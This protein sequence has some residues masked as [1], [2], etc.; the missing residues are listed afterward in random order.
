MRSR[1]EAMKNPLAASHGHPT[2]LFF[3]TYVSR[4]SGASHA[5]RETMRNVAACGIRPLVVL[6]DSADSREM[7]LNSE[8]EALYLKIHRPRRT[9]KAWVHARWAVNSMAMFFSLRRLLRERNVDVVHCNEV[10]D[11]VAGLAAKSGGVPCICHVR[12][13]RPPNPYR[14]L[15]LSTIEKV[16]DAVIV[17]S[18]CTAEW[19]TRGNKKLAQ[20]TRLIYDYAF[21]I[22]AYNSPQCGA[23]FRQELGIQPD[24]IMVLLV[25]KLVT[26]KGHE[27]FIRAAEKVREVLKDVRFVVVGGPVP[28]HEEEAEAIYS[29]A[30]RLTPAPQLQFA[31]ARADLPPIY[32]ASDIVVH[33]PTYRDP[34]PTVVLLAMAARRPIIGS[35]VGGIPEQI[36]HN[37]TGMLIPA[38]DPHAL[39]RAIIELSRN[40]AKRK[41]LETAG[42]DWVRHNFSPQTQ[43]RL[44]AAVYSQMLSI[45][46]SKN[47]HDVCHAPAVEGFL[48]AHD[49]LDA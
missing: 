35:M 15:L 25:S 41:L 42:S 38:N 29:L 12:T 24:E 8:F 19:L 39:A 40:P 3:S 17:T 37:H 48:E 22:R 23:A 4:E 45:P 2:V 20:R 31:G 13:D 27:C 18:K 28:G 36:E 46:D 5:L 21:D 10:T 1:T 34:Y 16:A 47:N 32:A 44:L 26:P 43:G 33:C 9:W 11:L 6:P 14:S 30:R 49:H 7:F